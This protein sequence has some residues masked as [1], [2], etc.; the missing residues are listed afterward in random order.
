MVSRRARGT[1]HFRPETINEQANRE[2]LLALCNTTNRIQS[3]TQT[4]HSPGAGEMPHTYWLAVNVELESVV[5]RVDP[6]STRS[7][8]PFLDEFSRTKSAKSIVL[9]DNSAEWHLLRK[10]DRPKTNVT[11]EVLGAVEPSAFAIVI[12]ALWEGS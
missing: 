2:L 9:S 4:E 5:G 10:N 8:P 3:N 1:C 7:V 12:A 6:A 11:A